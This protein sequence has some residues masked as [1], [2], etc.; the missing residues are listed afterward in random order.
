MVRGEV[1][2]VALGNDRRNMPPLRPNSY[3][4]WHHENDRAT[5]FFQ[6]ARTSSASFSFLKLE[7]YSREKGKLH[8]PIFAGDSIRID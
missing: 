5:S 1:L 2:G 4:P 3:G 7:E 6:T 8:E